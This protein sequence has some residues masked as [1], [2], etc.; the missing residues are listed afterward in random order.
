MPIDAV[1]LW[2]GFILTVLL[3]VLAVE[4][5]RRIGL[6][7]S[8]SAEPRLSISSTVGA[9]LG[10]LSFMLAFT[11]G[12]ASGR[13]ETRKRL[14]LEE[15]NAIGTTYLRAKMLPAP[16]GPESMRLL[17][18]YAQVRAG[19]VGRGA[20]ALREAIA[21]SE[22][23]HDSLWAQAVVLGEANPG[24]IVT[25]LYIQSLNEV[26][27]LH[28]A[29]LG[30]GERNRIQPT[31]WLGLYFMALIALGCVGYENGLTTPRRNPAATSVLAFIFASVFLLIVDLDRPTQG[32]F[33]VSQRFNI[34]L[35][36]KL[37]R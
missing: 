4:V 12:I 5:G 14:V 11:F 6:P 30:A 27:D 2:A 16:A 33:K 25:G 1:P 15:A 20:L 3:L 37:N 8:A 23:L 21:R 13:F 35:S 31:I 26:I 36:E 28:S 9:S 18:A 19:A 29:R 10:L 22:E 17:R 24:S 34:E 32:L 7:R